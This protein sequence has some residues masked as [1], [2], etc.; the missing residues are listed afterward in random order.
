MTDIERAMRAFKGMDDKRQKLIL[1]VLQAI[2]A[3]RPRRPALR[4]II[5]NRRQR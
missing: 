3:S 5:S 4:L 2:A 1:P